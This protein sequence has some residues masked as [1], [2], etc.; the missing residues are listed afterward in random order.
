MIRHTVS[1]LS[2]AVARAQKLSP[3]FDDCIAGVSNTL[4]DER[5]TNAVAIPAAELYMM[6]VVCFSL[7]VST[8]FLEF[9]YIVA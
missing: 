5:R 6:F 4:E 7:E 1:Y 9:G 3:G 2:S 8:Y